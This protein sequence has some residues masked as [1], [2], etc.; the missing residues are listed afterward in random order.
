MTEH[1]MGVRERLRAKRQQESGVVHLVLEGPPDVPRKERERRARAERAP[2][3]R[4]TAPPPPPVTT[5]LSRAPR[6]CQRCSQEIEGRR[7]SARYCKP[8][9]DLIRRTRRVKRESTA[10][11]IACGHCGAMFAQQHGRERYCC[12]RCQEAAK[13]QRKKARSKAA[14]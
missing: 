13:W 2:A 14:G 4:R 12:D 3:P 7:M 8:C 6:P 1:V 5:K 10:T 11:T 9:A